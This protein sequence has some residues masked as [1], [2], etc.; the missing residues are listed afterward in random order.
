MK[1]GKSNFIPKDTFTSCS[2]WSP[3]Q[4]MLKAP[5]DAVQRLNKIWQRTCREKH[6]GWHIW[7]FH[8]WA[9]IK[10][11]GRVFLKESGLTLGIPLSQG[12]DCIWRPAG[13][14]CI[15]WYISLTL[16]SSCTRHCLT[17][18]TGEN[19]HYDQGCF[20]V[21]G[22]VYTNPDTSERASFSLGFGFSST[23]RWKTENWEFWRRSPK[24]INLKML[25][26]S[27]SKRKYSKTMMHV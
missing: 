20:H 24:W 3:F 14:V 26:W 17:A 16:Y 27:C 25:F 22:S 4:V 21:F 12:H 6:D 1:R 8:L 15:F 5:L 10:G 2:Y 7:T 9:G 18:G 23:L 11:A 13:L 19:V